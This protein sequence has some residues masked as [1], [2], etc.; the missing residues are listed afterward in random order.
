MPIRLTAQH[1]RQRKGTRAGHPATMRYFRD[2]FTMA[3]ARQATLL[4][5]LTLTN[6][7]PF[8]TTPDGKGAVVKEL[9]A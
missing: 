3:R 4:Q 5:A 2:Q 6:G 9:R 7:R 1:C 8:Y